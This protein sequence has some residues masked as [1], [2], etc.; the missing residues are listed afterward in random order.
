MSRLELLPAKYFTFYSDRQNITLLKHF[1]KLKDGAIDYGYSFKESAVA[2][3]QIEGNRLDLDT[4]LK[5]HDTGMNT[6][7]KSYREI[8][9]LEEAYRFAKKYVPN[10]RNFLAAHRIMADPNEFEEKYRGRYRDRP[11]YVGVGRIKI[12]EG[13]SPGPAMLLMQNLF[14]DIDVLRKR[15]LTMNQV[16]YYASLIHLYT[17]MIH[18]F[19]DGNGRMARLLE[20]WFLADKLG[21]KAWFIKSEKMYRKRYEAYR[22]NLAELGPSWETTNFDKSIHFLLML[23]TALRTN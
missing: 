20:K 11:V 5:Y 4:Y 2:S 3:S 12:Y 8:Y 18:P 21:P 16:F 10:Q 7:T 23:P 22:K 6:A 9:F 14:H 1:N 13:P 17:V 15:D 19:A